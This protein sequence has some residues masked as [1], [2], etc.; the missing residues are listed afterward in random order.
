MKLT[1]GEEKQAR[2]YS[3]IATGSYEYMAKDLARQLEQWGR[4]IRRLRINE[5]SI[6]P[7]G[8]KYYYFEKPSYLTEFDT[9]I[10]ALAYLANK[11][12]RLQRAV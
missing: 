1:K 3:S 10:E 8:G 11:L 12:K 9:N 5:T 2:L 4:I 7:A 6:C